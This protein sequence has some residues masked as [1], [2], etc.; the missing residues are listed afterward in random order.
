MKANQ[1]TTSKQSEPWYNDL[2]LKSMRY[3]FRSGKHAAQLGSIHNPQLSGEREGKPKCRR[4][5][6]NNQEQGPQCYEQFVKRILPEGEK[7]CQSV[8]QDNLLPVRG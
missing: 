8:G 1:T 4:S 7:F 2:V 3:R 5:R 6:H